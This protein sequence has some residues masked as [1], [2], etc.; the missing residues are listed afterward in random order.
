MYMKLSCITRKEK[1]KEKE[2]ACS[3]II[4]FRVEESRER[5]YLHDDTRVKREKRRIM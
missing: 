1:K 3:T 4:F 2:I 5:V